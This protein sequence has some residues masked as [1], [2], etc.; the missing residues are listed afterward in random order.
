MTSW[1]RTL[2]VVAVL[3]C[4]SVPICPAQGT[5]EDYQ[6]A[7]QF[8]PGNLR[9]RVYIAEVIPHW[10]AE[11]SR[12]WYR[13]AGTKGT[14]FIL[15]DRERN[16]SGPAFD[17][18]RLAV[19]L[20]KATKRDYQPTELPFDTFD[21]AKDAK[22]V[23]FQVEGTPWTCQLENYECK[24]GPEPLAGQYEEASPNKEWVAYVKEHD[25]Y[26]RYAATGEIVRL[27]RDGEE[28]WDYATPIPSLRPM[29]AQGTQD[30]KQRPAVFWSPDSSKLVT[31]RMDTRNAGRFT[32]LQFVPPGQLRPKAFS[33]VYPLPGEV[34][35][36][37]DPVIFDVQKG[38]RIDVKTPSLEVQ[39]QGGPGFEWF[40]DNKT[41]YYEAEERGEKAIELRT[42]D[43]E[44]GEQ[45]VVVREKS[46][47]YVDPGETF[48]RFLHVSEEILWS[49]ER[50]GWNH[51]YLY[52]QKTG[53]L[54]NQVTRGPWV[55]RSIVAV[56]E[57]SRRVYFLANGREKGEDPYQTHLYSIGLDGNNVT[58]LTPSNANHTVS[59]SPDH[60]CFVD[61]SSRP[62]LP[63]E[64][65]LRSVKDGSQIRVLEQTDAS[66]LLKENWKFP[67]AFQGKAKDGATDLYGLIWRPSNFDATKKYPIIEMVYTGPQAFFVP[68]TFGAA[69]RGLQ[70][71]AELGFIVVMVD[72][73]GTTGRSRAFHEFSYRNLGGAF[74]DHVAMIQQMAARYSYMDATRVGI[75]GTSA[76]AYGAAHAMLAFP[77]FY[78]V[79]IAISGDHDARL[80]KAWWNELYQGFP[81]GPDYAEQSNVTMADRL[82]GHLLIEHGDVDDNVHVVETMRFADA[83]MKANK[84]FDM[85]IVPN[86]Y[87]GEGG[88]LYLVRRRWDYFVRNLLGVTPPGNFEIHED[89]EASPAGSR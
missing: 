13:K 20:S 59:L 88:N 36:K 86:M 38:R 74:E 81:V 54:K 71:V 23:S 64:V 57:K 85:L 7:Q 44:T 12:F 35:P 87:H 73:R 55:V 27:T 3:V 46:D 78:K 83:L 53:A 76:G 22:S 47:H 62:D 2:A 5:R 82:Q 31:Y 16:T 25:L 77:D 28:S 41:I 63:G 19:S 79:G 8:L 66:E 70:S 9:H 40:P 52:D 32:N 39:F 14:D 58:A 65:I 49:S 21:Y 1:C 24:R 45:K 42:V 68:K 43:S 34:L 56:D 69:L 75:F 67:E 60:F 10:I 30:V 51:L 50:D 17:H 33:V 72:G 11:K 6:R 84:D 80:D 37:A 48:F 26:L 61:N 4:L 29:V 89:R 18:A 15:V